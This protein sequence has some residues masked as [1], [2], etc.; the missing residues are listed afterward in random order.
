VLRE[1]TGDLPISLSHGEG[2]T[3]PLAVG[4][5][6]RVLLAQYDDRTLQQLLPLLEIPAVV[7]DFMGD[8]E[9]RLQEIARIRA[10]GYALSAG[11]M[12]PDSTGI[13]VPV[14]G[15][16]CP[17]ALSLFG[18]RFRF[19]PLTALQEIREAADRISEKINS[20][21]NGPAPGA[22]SFRKE[23]A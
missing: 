16:V 4:S 8:P 18:P 5:A 11:E 17:V 12:V 14:R 21:L 22:G 1:I 10:A 9:R 2:S 6:G 19:D 13:S 3:Q 20:L 7:P 23:T 15:Y